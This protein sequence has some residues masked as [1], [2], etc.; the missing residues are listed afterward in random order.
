MQITSPIQSALWSRVGALGRAFQR[1][2]GAARQWLLPALA[3]CCSIKG[4]WQ[5]EWRRAMPPHDIRCSTAYGWR[6]TA[7]ANSRWWQRLEELA[8]TMTMGGRGMIPDFR[9]VL[10]SQRCHGSL[11]A[12]LVSMPGAGQRACRVPSDLLT[13][14][15]L[16]DSQVSWRL[17][18]IV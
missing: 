14:I 15:L 8:R 18:H 1:Q 4:R 12:P 5:H 10:Q 2:S 3:P 11:P 6:I 13:L 9:A 7:V 16:F 17:P